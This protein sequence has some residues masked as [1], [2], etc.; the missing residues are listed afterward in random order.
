[1]HVLRTGRRLL[2]VA[3]AAF[4]A[5]CTHTQS[6]PQQVAGQVAHPYVVMVS[7]DAFRA[8]YIDRYMPPAMLGMAQRGVRAAALIPSFPSKTF[9]NHYTLVTGLYPGDHGIV[10]NS[11]YDPA[12]QASYRSSTPVTVRDG[13]WYGGEPIWATAE[14]NGVKSAA[15]FWAGSEAEIQGIRPSYWTAYDGKVPNEQRVATHALVGTLPSYTVLTR[16]N[17]L[18]FSPAST[19]RRLHHTLHAVRSAVP[20]RSAR[21]VA[22]RTRA[23]WSDMT[24]AVPDRR[25]SS[26][27]AVITG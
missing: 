3:L 13:S 27:D 2:H 4:A 9:P 16:A 7:F 26:D 12:R 21:R 23:C 5:S 15:Y 17:A 1:M 10:G 24:P 19:A 22:H 8:D 6:Q 11:F 20:P 25:T 14:R 18:D